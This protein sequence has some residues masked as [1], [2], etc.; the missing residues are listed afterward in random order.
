MTATWPVQTYPIASSSG[1]RASCWTIRQPSAS[2]AS[3]LGCFGSFQCTSWSGQQLWPERANH[4]HRC[5]LMW[6]FHPANKWFSGTNEARARPY[7]RLRTM[8]ADCWG[9]GFPDIAIG[10]LNDRKV[11]GL[12]PHACWILQCRLDLKS[13]H[14]SYIAQYRCLL[15][16]LH[17]VTF[18]TWLT[19]PSFSHWYLISVT[20]WQPVVN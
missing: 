19:Q 6:S 17:S 4:N 5:L 7:L 3:S 8:P 2:H 1:S 16:P 11:V 18:E 15:R 12:A 9:R 13:S 14:C 10:S 20:S